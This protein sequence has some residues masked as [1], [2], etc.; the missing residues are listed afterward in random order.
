M[1]FILPHIPILKGFAD[2]LGKKSQGEELRGGW[3]EPDCV[4]KGQ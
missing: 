1:V 3:S 4:G 2:A